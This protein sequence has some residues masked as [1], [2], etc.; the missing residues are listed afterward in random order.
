MRSCLLFFRTSAVG[1]KA[2]A[3]MLP[4][5]LHGHNTCAWNR[6]VD[7][8]DEVLVLLEIIRLLHV[9]CPCACRSDA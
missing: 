7:V 3:L 5:P 1:L 8:D 4:P 9:Y 6:W 2:W